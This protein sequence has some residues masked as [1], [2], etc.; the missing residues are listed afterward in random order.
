MI[1]L[2]LDIHS[3][4]QHYGYVG[5]FVILGLEV[6]GIPFPAE[7]TLTLTGIAWTA[8]TL[9]IVPLVIMAALGNIVGSTIA[10]G[11]GK[12]LG[13]AV[14]LRYGRY[15]GITD[16]RLSRVE[17]QFRKYQWGILVVGKFIAG[18]RV[19][20]PYL[21][22]LNAMPFIRFTIV[23]S[24]SAVVW[25]VTFVLLGNYIGKL[26][27]NVHPFIMQYLGLTII[28]AA[29]LLGLYIWWKVHERKKRIRRES[30]ASDDA[31]H[32]V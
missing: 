10:Y 22:G 1:S 21:A 26:W 25:V 18:I 14:I 3:L 6:V 24:I 27:D 16:R 23:N 15:V 31:S 20:I 13:R 17:E 28:I 29:V 2:H 8:G 30:E 11:I 32:Y 7:T 12:Y 5:V 4:L 9:S 19:L